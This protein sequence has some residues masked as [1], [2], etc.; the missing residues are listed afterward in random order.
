MRH[1]GRAW[2][3]VAP[4]YV[5]AA[6]SMASWPRGRPRSGTFRLPVPRPDRSAA[7]GARRA[8]AGRVGAPPPSRAP[9]RRFR[10]TFIDHTAVTAE[11]TIIDHK[12][13]RVQC[14]HPDP[15][16]TLSHPASARWLERSARAVAVGGPHRRDGPRAVCAGLGRRAEPFGLRIAIRRSVAPF[17]AAR[18]VKKNRTSR[19]VRPDVY[20][21]TPPGARGTPA[22]AAARPRRTEQTARPPPREANIPHHAHDRPR[23]SR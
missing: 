19:Y 1:G 6:R 21:T 12:T 20:A 8:P 10:S 11:L 3:R 2:S 17:G 13:Q 14:P 7:G 18:S 16:C 15:L 5:G 23:P 9:A 22:R 4:T